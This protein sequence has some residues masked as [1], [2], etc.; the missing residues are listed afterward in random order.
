VDG[1]RSERAIDRRDGDDLQGHRR[2]LRRT[3]AGFKPETDDE[4]LRVRGWG[5][6]GKPIASVTLRLVGRPVARE[7]QPESSGLD[8]PSPAP[9]VPLAPCPGCMAREQQI[10]ARITE[11][12]A[13][14]REASALREALD[15]SRT[16]RAAALDDLREVRRALNDARSTLA[17]EAT[18]RR[19][20]AA[21]RDAASQTIVDLLAEVAELEEV[22]EQAT[23]TLQEL[24]E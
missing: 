10:S 2:W 6:G 22:I 19:R 12:A 13:A 5:A 4:K 15:L 21:E 17:E 16:A 8:A 9:P 3:I 23:A 18:V 11:N 20:V 24:N 14:A 1:S 7:Q